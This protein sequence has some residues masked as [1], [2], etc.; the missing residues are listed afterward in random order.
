MLF[1]AKI[2]PKSYYKI[3]QNIPS[4]AFLIRSS[5][6]KNIV[7]SLTG[8]ISHKAIGEPSSTHIPDLSTSLFGPF[9]EEHS[10]IRILNK[11]LGCYIKPPF[12]NIDIPV[13]GEDFDFGF[14]FGYWFVEIEKIHNKKIIFIKDNIKYEAICIVNHTPTLWNFWH[15][16]VNWYLPLFQCFWH[17][18]SENDSKKSWAAKSLAHATRNLIKMN[19]TVKDYSPCHLKRESY[20]NYK[21]YILF[22]LNNINFL[23][24]IKK[25]R[26]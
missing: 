19:G 6:D 21:L 15:Y 5:R 25:R 2:L 10:K 26:K 17:D 8:F 24:K 23:K 1:P 20:I 14:L 4:S 12:N 22:L 18:L 7:D 3:I 13:M 16:S 9:K 11:S